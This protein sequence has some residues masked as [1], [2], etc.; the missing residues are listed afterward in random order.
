MQLYVQGRDTLMNAKH[1]QMNRIYGISMIALFLI[2]ILSSLTSKFYSADGAQYLYSLLL[3]EELFTFQ[4][5]RIF[6]HYLLKI[7]AWLAIKSGVTHFKTISFLLGFAFFLQI[8]ISL[9]V[10]R[11]FLGEKKKSFLI[12]PIISTFVLVLNTEYAIESES[13]TL[14][15]FFWPVFIY[16]YHYEQMR[17][18]FQNIVFFLCALIIPYTYETFF[19][20]SLPLIYYIVKTKNISIMLLFIPYYV[21]TSFHQLYNTVF[22]QHPDNAERFLT[23][24]YLCFMGLFP[25]GQIKLFNPHLFSI[26]LL[27]G[28]LLYLF[29]AKNK[30]VI[31]PFIVLTWIIS[32]SLIVSFPYLI[33]F[34]SQFYSRTLTAL[35][36]LL[37]VFIVFLLKN[38]ILKEKVTKYFRLIIAIILM[39]TTASLVT[40]Y[41]WVQFKNNLNEDNKKHVGVYH[42]NIYQNK[43]VHWVNGWEVRGFQPWSLPIFALFL[44]ENQTIKSIPFAWEKHPITLQ[45]IKEIKDGTKLQKY[46]FKFEK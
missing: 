44:S 45:Q 20:C 3:S 16:L 31:Y 43:T 46:G 30:K 14:V 2:G 13:I 7:P 39:Q 27:S 25:G 29:K 32:L 8:M 15:S 17:T 5:G 12:F 10:S 18:T 34:S 41:H 22:H 38:I 19:V 24:V 21:I 1:D 23:S 4:E 28:Y 42:Y 36:P 6:A 37:M 35:S 33:S 11:W 40:T 9:F 26:L